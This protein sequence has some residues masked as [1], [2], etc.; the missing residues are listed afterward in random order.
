MMRVLENFSGYFYNPV[1]FW[2]VPFLLIVVIWALRKIKT[3]HKP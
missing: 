1:V 3:E 2:G